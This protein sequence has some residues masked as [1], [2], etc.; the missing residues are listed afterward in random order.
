MKKILVFGA[1]GLAGSQIVAESLKAGNAVTVYIR[2]DTY[3]FQHQNLTVLQ[4]SLENE[5]GIQKAMQGQDVIISAVGNMDLNDSTMVVAPLT[6]R[7]IQFIEPSQRF[8]CLLGSGSLL[9]DFKTM[10]KD[11]P[12]QS[13][14]F[15]YP[16]ADHWETLISI[17]PLDIDY[18]FI[19]PP[20][21][22]AGEADG[23]YNIAQLY[24]PENSQGFI[25]AGNI[26]Y[27]VAQEID[28]QVFVRTRVG[29]ATKIGNL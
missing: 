12:N 11:L 25:T 22:K 13:T 6:K 14:M 7:I 10:R 29:I 20:Q 3:P 27:F 17:V 5:L 19:C 18:T 9:H 23:N 24:F 8:I 21:I 2:K 1:T 26:G 4:D 15:Q 16:R 28:N